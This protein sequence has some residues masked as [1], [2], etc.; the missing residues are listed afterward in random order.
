M[1]GIIGAMPEEIA[2]VLGNMTQVSETQKGSRTYYQGTLGQQKVV[3]CESGIGK[4]NS[5]L[6]AA[7][8]IYVFNVKAI[9]FTGVAG[10]V[11]PSLNLG[12]LVIGTNF[13]YHDFDAT[14]V[15]YQLSQIPDDNESS[16]FYANETLSQQF[17]DLAVELFGS[18]KVYRGRIVSGDEF[19][20]SQEKIQQLQTL[21]DAYATDMESAS[22][23][24]VANK[25]HIPCCIIRAISDKSDGVAAETYTNFFKEAAKNAALLVVAFTEHYKI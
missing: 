18:N 23:A 5:A 3:L 11:L 25:C 4:V 16:I 2:L 22:V 8:L 17:T 15:G 14:A 10:G 1:L 7:T 6:T 20:A 9:V 13:L 12:D 24:H 21:F 19:V